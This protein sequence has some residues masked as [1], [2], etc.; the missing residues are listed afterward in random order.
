MLKIT[1]SSIDAWDEEKG[2]FVQKPSETIRLEHSLAAIS[3]WESNYKKPFLTKDE[4]TIEEFLFYIKCMALDDIDD[5]FMLRITQEHLD[6]IQSYIDDPMTAS[7]VTP[8]ETNSDRTII[9]SELIYF[10]LVSA[11]IPF[12]TQNWH[13]NRLL[14]LIKI[15][16]EKTKPQKKRRPSDVLEE[17]R[18]LNEMRRREL[19]T[20][21]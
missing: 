13:L 17:Q 10:W 1:L 3:K 21:G 5:S 19:G 7:W 18:R 15:F 6:T 9:T 16:G 14:M 20:N 4:K 2:E 8:S 11:Q 12:E